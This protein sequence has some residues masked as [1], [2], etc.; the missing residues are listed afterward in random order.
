MV[1]IDEELHR[2]AKEKLLNI[3]AVVDRALR[4]NMIP[5]KS[6]LPEEAVTMKCTQCMKEI[7]YG[8]LCRERKLFLCQDCQ[9]KFDIGRCPHDQSGQHMHIRIPGFEGQNMEYLRTLEK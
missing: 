3:S 2:K 6:D 1:S 5:K 8:F 7:E 9:D 4:E